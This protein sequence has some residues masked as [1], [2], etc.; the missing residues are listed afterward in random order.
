M[1]ATGP[2]TGDFTAVKPYAPSMVVMSDSIFLLGPD[3]YVTEA[4]STTYG[5]E[6]DLQ[7]L[8]ADNVELL[9][10]VQINPSNPRRWL[11][12][13]REAGIPNHEGGASFW[14]IDHLLVDQ[15]AVPTFVEVKRASDSRTRREVV[16][17]MLDCAAN[18][19]LF[20]TPERLRE[21]FEDSE[22]ES[23][24]DR[25]VRWLDPSAEDPESVAEAFWAA[26]GTNLREGRIRLIF[27]ADEIPAS[28]Q[29]LVE[30]LNEQMPR[31]EVLAVEIRQY[32]AAG[33]KSGALVPRLIGQTAR[34]MATK[35]APTTPSRRSKPWTID[36]VTASA[37]QA[38]E[39]E[40]AAAA[41]IFRWIRE[42]ADLL[43]ITGGTG[44][45]YPSVTVSADSGRS[46]SRF[47]PVLALYGSPHGAQPML[48][49]RVAR[50]CRTPPYGREELQQPLL[51]Q[52]EEVGFDHVEA[53]EIRTT[54]RRPNIALSRLTD[55]KLAV[56]LK[57][58]DKWIE[59]VRSH[60]GESETGDGPG[61]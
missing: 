37:A 56:L 20:W 34:A 15:D 61:A 28:L 18:G 26:V 10:G 3:R 14:S 19:S 55:D 23:G 33:N 52:L 16:A 39:S 24:T 47:R 13:R 41:V 7:A 5:L 32:L 6:A 25:L 29:R 53:E 2:K 50:M 8:L 42:R 31:I 27:V 59:D 4:P 46:D 21:W 40:R 43:K 48:E 57:V 45:S 60:A 1:S 49:V 11:L 58:V 30:F 54:D 38:G 12:I 44:L 36:E 17:Q 9:P 51:T 22:P 35:E